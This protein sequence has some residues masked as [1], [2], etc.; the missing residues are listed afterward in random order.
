MPKTALMPEPPI[1]DM[2]AFKEWLYAEYDRLTRQFNLLDQQDNP[3]SHNYH[4][5]R[6]EIIE[7]GRAVGV[8][9]PK[10]KIIGEVDDN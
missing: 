2:E 1:N 5:R 10:N 8:E 4:Q 7:V 6:L 9:L 3:Q